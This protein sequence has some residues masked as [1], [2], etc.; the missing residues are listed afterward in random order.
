MA[1]DRVEQTQ[2]V[3]RAPAR[4]IVVRPPADQ[5]RVLEIRRHLDESRE[6]L[7]AALVQVRASARELTPAARIAHRPLRWVAGGFALGFALGFL[8]RARS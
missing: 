5:A 7:R 6:R 3:L 1:D 8:F 4:P 2:M